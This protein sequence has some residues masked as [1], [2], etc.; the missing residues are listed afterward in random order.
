MCALALST[1]KDI[2]A[3]AEVS[4]LMQPVIYLYD[5]VSL[6]KKTFLALEENDEMIKNYYY[7][8]FKST[9]S[10]FLCAAANGN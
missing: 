6:R 2:V 9:S 4:N 8:K 1:N 3:V 5:S 10:D 7:L